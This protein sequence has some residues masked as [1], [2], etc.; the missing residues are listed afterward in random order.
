MN[1]GNYGC[2]I[3]TQYVSLVIITLTLVG[4]WLNDVLMPWVIV[5]LFWM[6]IPAVI[7]AIISFF[8]SL[9]CNTEHKRILIGLHLVNIT[10][11]AFLLF[12][13]G[14]KCDADIMEAH[15]LKYGGRMEKLYKN[16][17]DRL[18][19]E[20]GIEIEFE[21][22][23]VSMFHV[24]DTTGKWNSN[25]DPSEEKTDSLLQQLEL[26]RAFLKDL[27]KQLKS[28]GCISILIEA[29]PESPYTIGFRRIGM[30]MYSYRIYRKPL[31]ADVQKEFQ[32]DDYT[33][34]V[35]SPYVV[36][37]YGGGAIGNQNFLG[38]EEYLDKKKHKAY[39]TD[40]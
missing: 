20:R 17:Y 23:K 21:H 22:G 18:Q 11:F 19:P 39:E 27:K 33:S 30:G 8:L 34:I 3:P 24:T 31:S 1:K 25:W 16:V 15:Y 40:R 12:Y 10:L 14:N 37:V 28:I 32:E 7:I 9:R 6:Y 2:W 4:F 26:D 35:F 29:N 5:L 13:P 36:F 38:K